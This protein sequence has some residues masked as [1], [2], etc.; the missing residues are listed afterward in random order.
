M[1]NP[2][3]YKIPDWFLNR[4]KDIKD[5]KFSQVNMQ[6]YHPVALF[7]FIMPLGH[8]QHAWEQTSWRPRKTKENPSPSWST[9]L[10]GVLLWTGFIIYLIL[11]FCFIITACEFAVNTQKQLVVVD[12]LSVSRKRS[13][14]FL[15]VF[16]YF[17][18]EYCYISQYI[19]GNQFLYLSHLNK[20]NFNV[21][22][23]T[24]TCRINEFQVTRWN[25]PRL[26]SALSL[27]KIRVSRKCAYH[28][29][30]LRI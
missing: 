24:L 28:I 9:S 11:I 23:F 19:H 14:K 25:F 12:A 3:Q 4:Q 8:I 10:L 26:L 22:I 7:N 20:L 15:A 13:R 5:G 17:S 27:H 6:V 30:D 21:D 29:N 16:E 18:V 1:A 2:R